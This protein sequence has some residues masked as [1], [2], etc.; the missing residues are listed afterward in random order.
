MSDCNSEA[1][2]KQSQSH[3]HTCHD[4]SWKFLTEYF[5]YC[6]TAVSTVYSSACHSFWTDKLFIEVFF[7]YFYQ[8]CCC[9][10]LHRCHRKSILGVLLQCCHN[11]NVAD[12]ANRGHSHPHH[13]H[14]PNCHETVWNYTFGVNFMPSRFINPNLNPMLI[15]EGPIV[16]TNCQAMTVLWDCWWIFDELSLNLQKCVH[17]KVS[18]SVWTSRSDYIIWQ[19]CSPELI[20][21]M[22]KTKAF[23]SPCGD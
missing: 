19:L 1:G 20:P 7:F 18:D 12:A 14:L 5:N 17:Q 13:L 21:S 10:L 11:A 16:T 8:H 4:T 23:T 6:S 2:N 22:L 15:W 9:T 3:Q